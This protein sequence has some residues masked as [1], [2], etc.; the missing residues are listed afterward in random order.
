[1]EKRKPLSILRVARQIS[2]E[3]SQSLSSRTTLHFTGQTEYAHTKT[4]TEVANISV[5]INAN[6]GTIFELDQEENFERASVI[7]HKREALLRREFLKGSDY[8]LGR[9]TGG[10]KARETAHL[11]FRPIGSRHGAFTH[12]E[13]HPPLICSQELRHNIK[14]YIGFRNVVMVLEFVVKAGDAS[15]DALGV[16]EACTN[17]KNSRSH[18]VWN[19]A[20]MLAEKE[21]VESFSD[22]DQARFRRLATD[23][24]KDFEKYLGAFTMHFVDRAN[25]DFAGILTYHPREASDTIT[26]TAAMAEEKY[27]QMVKDMKESSIE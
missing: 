19:F 25:G 8:L 11:H 18:E 16:G 24:G 13:D 14:Q 15:L 5:T 26:R 27:S 17:S 1:M 20:R 3:A 6:F 23:V 10:W 21:N 12:F 7:H 2:R 9:F 22:Q 4:A